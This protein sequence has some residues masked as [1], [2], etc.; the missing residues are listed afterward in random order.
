MVLI[1]GKHMTLKKISQEKEKA[2]VHKGS[3]LIT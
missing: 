1:T 3:V 2:N